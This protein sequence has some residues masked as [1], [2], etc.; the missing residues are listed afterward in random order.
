MSISRLHTDTYA[1]TAPLIRKANRQ[2]LALSG[3][4]HT[5]F[6]VELLTCHSGI[7]YTAQQVLAS[8]YN[9]SQ[10][11]A[12][13]LKSILVKYST[14]FGQIYRPIHIDVYTVLRLPMMDGRSVRNM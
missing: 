8:S 1:T 11:D 12:L 14:C 7:K 2:Q 13:F 5:F 4:R 3:F 9:K 6:V 10:R